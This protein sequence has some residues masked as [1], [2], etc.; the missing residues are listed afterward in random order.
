MT[1]RVVLVTATLLLSA[2]GASNDDAAPV[3]PA[4]PAAAPVEE[5]VAATDA[6]SLAGTKWRLIEFQSMDDGQ[7]TTAPDDRSKYVMQ[8]NDDGSVNM[9]LNCNRATG[10]WTAEASSDESGSFGFG[11][12]AMTRALCPPP[13][14][15]EQIGM[16]AEYIRSYLLRDGN[17]YL[18][19]MADGGI[20]AWEPLAD[21]VSIETAP[22][23]AIEA[24]ILAAYPDYNQDVVEPGRE[25]RYVYSRIDLNDDGQDEVLAYLLG[26][27]F[28]GTGGCNLLLLRS[29]GDGYALVNSFPTTSTPVIIAAEKSNGWNDIW[30]Y[31]TGGGAPAN[32]IANRFDGKAYVDAEQLSA[33]NAPAGKP[34]LAGTPDFQQAIVLEPNN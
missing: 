30:R 10:S 20:Y 3:E 28:C 25:S 18:S 13:S 8:L 21:E 5:T 23:P 32:Y 12:L 17:L 19:L 33:E 6:N 29:T 14:M 26:P 27:Y 11:P 31:R 1:S 4:E 22:N 34:V 16:H 24:A 9:Q 2:C 15:D 7:G